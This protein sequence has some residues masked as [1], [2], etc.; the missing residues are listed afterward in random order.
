MINICIVEDEIDQAQQL[1]GFIRDYEKAHNTAFCIT[2]LSDGLDLVEGYS[3]QFD[4]ILLDIQMK[5]MNGMDAA[6]RVRQLDKDV[7]IIFITSTVQYAVQ[8]YAVDALGYVLKPV[9]PAAFEKLLEKSIERVNSSK[10]RTYIKIAVDD[11]QLKL[12]CDDITYIESS[13]NN[14]IV[15]CSNG[16][17]HTTLGPLKK[18]EELLANKGF[19]KCHNAYLVNLALVDAIQKEEVLLLNGTSLPISRAK[20]KEFMSA[21]T[22]DII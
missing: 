9:S 18:F 16:D 20:K 17:A 8:G 2:K 12:A 14:V 4:I 5:H 13:R 7:V 21:L 3:G 19:S 11:K 1:H 10:E 6:E 15:H 22:E